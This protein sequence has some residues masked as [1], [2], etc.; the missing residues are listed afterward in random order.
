VT[1][2]L[3]DSWTDDGRADA[4]AAAVVHQDGAVERRFAGAADERSLFALASVSKPIVAIAALVA[5]EEGSIDLDRP[6]AEHLPAYGDAA[7]ARI[8]PRHLLSHASG[9]PESSRGTPPLEV[10]PEREPGVRRVY[11]NEGFHVLG[12]LLVEATGID[13]PRYLR[14]AVIEPL[15]MEAFMPLPEAE[16]GRALEV[17][18]P[19]LSAP[20][21]ALFNDERWRRR[22][23]AAGGVFATLEGVA[24]FAQMLLARGAPLLAEETFAEFADVQFPGIP[25]GLES[26]SKLHCPDWGLGMNVRGHGSPHWL[27]DAVAP[28][29]LSH[30]G[31]SGTLLFAD[32]HS[33]VG[34]VC[35][36]NRGTYSGWMLQPG[37]WPELCAAVVAGAPA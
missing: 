4:V 18:D 9:L 14:E 20:G 25:G 35:L 11:S 22:I 34:L 30:F 7:R 32:P 21:I 29:T 6:V 5:A 10:L 26:F 15:G 33:G 8:T 1:L 36:A 17:R 23:N 19:G 2:E 28:S 27:G 31:A 12:L 13:L 16:Y 24:C 3:I 37:G